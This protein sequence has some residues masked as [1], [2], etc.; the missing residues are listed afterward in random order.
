MTW[1]W[2]FR[3]LVC[4][5]IC[6]NA[7]AQQAPSPGSLPEIVANVN[8]LEISKA[9]LLRRADALQSQLPASE[10]P[11]DFYRRVLDELI[12]DE[13]LY[14]AVEAKNLAP[15]QAEIDSEF[16]NQSK[17]F[18]G[19]AA[20]AEALAK[21]GISPDQ[22]KLDLKKE[23]GI[24]RLVE[25]ELV[26]QVTV[27]EEE[28][29]TYYDANPEEMRGSPD[30]R[31]AHILIQVRKDATAE[32]KEAARKKA[33]SLRSMIEVGQDFADLARRNS[34]DPGSKDN[35][36]ELPFMSKGQT[37]PP[38]EAAAMA[39]EIG[40]MS[41]VVETQFGFH[42]LKLLELRGGELIPY[43]E[44]QGRIE[45]YLLRLN[46]Q[47][48]LETEVETLRSQGTVEVFI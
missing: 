36:G 14:Q 24:Q 17:G 45:E 37:V 44:V 32:V 4:C 23:I 38:F 41:D 22:V 31:V 2:L 47:K 25:R 16:D 15:S 29:R 1:R 13:L 9:E 39:L 46:L 35:G 28:K 7:I 20:F 8:G 42:I 3:A 30:F 10:V 40:E 26:P 18:G 43:E 5:A 33:S 21:R 27:S 34:G 11:P 6:A 19:K 12:D 48:R